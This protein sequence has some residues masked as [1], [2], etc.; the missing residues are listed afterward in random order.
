MGVWLG[1][2]VRGCADGG[3]GEWVRGCVSVFV[4]RCVLLLLLLPL[5][6]CPQSAVLCSWPCEGQNA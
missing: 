1:A 4:S 5:Q 6:A 2:W 3:V